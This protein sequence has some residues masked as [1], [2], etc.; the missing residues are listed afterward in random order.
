M[1]SRTSQ[2]DFLWPAPPPDATFYAFLFQLERT[3][4]WSAERLRADQLLELST[5]IA[6]AATHAPFQK[7]RIKGLGR[8]GAGGLSDDMFEALPILTRAEAVAAGDALAKPRAAQRPWRAAGVDHVGVLG[9]AV[10]VP[11]HA[12]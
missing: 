5:L 10:P 6:H 1:S 11:A 12:A 2:A 8:L 7:D 4:W 9:H 3:Q